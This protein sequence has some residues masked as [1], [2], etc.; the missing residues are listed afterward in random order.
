MA[1]KT[2]KKSLL[3]CLIALLA[4]IA[5][6]AGIAFT[7]LQKAAADDYPLTATETDSDDGND[8]PLVVYRIA[9][10]ADC[11]F[12]GDS[13]SASD[14]LRAINVS[15]DSGRPPSIANIR[16]LTGSFTGGGSDY[17]QATKTGEDFVN[18]LYKSVD[19]GELVETEFYEA[20]CGLL[21]TGV[22]L[23]KTAVTIGLGETCQ[24][25]ATTE[26]EDADDGITWTSDNEKVATVS[27]SGE[28]TAVATGKATIHA[29]TYSEGNASEAESAMGTQADDEAEAIAGYEATCVVTVKQA[30]TITA[31]DVTGEVGEPGKKIEATTNGGGKL[32]Y[33]VTSGSDYVSV[34]KTGA[35]T[36]KKAGTAKVTVTAA[37][38]KNYAP[39]KKVVTVTVTDVVPIATYTLTYDANGGTGTM[40]KVTADAG[41]A[42]TLAANKFTRNGYTFAGWNTAKDGSGASY[43]DQAE[44]K[45]TEDMTLYAQWTKTAAAAA[46]GASPKTGDTLPTVLFACIAAAAAAILC[47]TGV[48]V[49]KRR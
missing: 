28:V 1:E 32:S 14:I 5:V 35:L 15:F 17:L 40:D 48:A 29:K 4:G 30:Q 38:T 18:F 26:P 41:T 3:M 12:L 13:V 9:D 45:L 39:G 44:V 37:E 20:T 8:R 16:N 21:P 36:L 2:Q 46:K 47:G 10:F 7:P 11:V 42:I 34:D 23:D 6:A 43:K 19:T 31:A 27:K 25:T 24:L 49:R 33:K 22:K